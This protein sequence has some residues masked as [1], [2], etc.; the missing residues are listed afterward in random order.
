MP[1][2]IVESPAKCSK[3]KG[4]L[5][6]GYDVVASMGHIRALEASLDSVGIDRDFE[7]RFEFQKEKSKAIS[8][9]K[10][11]AKYHKIVILASDDDREG[12]A[13][14]YSLCLLLKLDHKKTPRA[15]FH[16]ITKDAVVNAVNNPRLLD[17]NKVNAQQSRAILDMLVGYS[18]SPLLWNHVGH[19]LSA[20]RCQT[21][22][23]RLVSEKEN[24]IKDFSSSCSW[25]V[26]GGWKHGE[27]VFDAFL[28]DDL[29]DMESAKMYLEMRQESFKA[30]IISAVTKPT[31]EKPPRPLITS[32]LQQQASSLLRI[33]PKDTM[34]IAQRLYEA[35]HITYM[36]TDKAV[37]SEDAVKEGTQWIETTLGKEYVGVGVGVSVSAGNVSVKEKSKSKI[38]KDETKTQ[39]AHEAIRPTHMDMEELSK[40]EDWSSKDRKLYKI[41]WTRALQSL[42][43][44]TKGERRTVEFRAEGDSDDWTW[45]SSWSRMIFDGWRRLNWKEIQEDDEKES[46]EEDWA[47]ALTLREGALVKWQELKA[48]PHF[49]KAPSRYTE[50][51]LIKDLE[52]KGIGRPSTFA[53]LVSTIMD[54]GYVDKKDFEGKNVKIEW[55]KML[56]NKKIE[57]NSKEIRQN[58]EKDRMVPSPLGQSVLTYLLA[59]F[60]DLFA[61]E[62]TS[63][64]EK[65]L[66]DIAEGKEEWK[67]VLRDTWSSYKDRYTEQLAIKKTKNEK[68]SNFRKELGEGIVAIVIKKGPLLLKESED[69]NKDKT[70]FY[71]WPTNI[72]FSDIT[73]DAAKTF[74]SLN[75]KNKI[76]EVLGEI[77]GLQV[78][79][80]KGPYGFY[81]EWNGKR[82]ACK[83]DSTFEMVKE[84]LEKQESSVLKKIGQFEIRNGPYGRYMFKPA[85][86]KKEFVSLPESTK[87][88]D[89]KEGDCIALFQFGLQQKAKSKSYSGR[90]GARGGAQ[91]S[92]GGRGGRGGRGRG[93]RGRKA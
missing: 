92:R 68:E 74:I 41:I 33:N 23:L 31:S 9:I 7:A 35:G 17:M 14:A 10:E 86:T 20:G 25:K 39:D 77:D 66:D 61:Y 57:V 72:Q 62:F 38:K 88:D 37:I 45:R 43:S 13:I 11:A 36:R 91:G 27:T 75:E 16:E 26:E 52:E 40:D 56:L 58:N 76:G 29:E 42:M 78:L 79:K 21:P 5:G 87:L 81:V 12:E 73:L 60:E 50:A 44:P 93:F 55:L 48:E 53:M 18:I 8:A 47:F 84:Q 49:T 30:T 70:I 51:T 67:Q 85:A 46:K 69:K 90:G 82:L 15:V 54:K 83:D 63:K 1:L 89:L 2:V 19:S 64:M 59:N 24:S 71:G 22:A 80:K 4:F 32:S 65:R 6:Q 34:S 28:T 3:I